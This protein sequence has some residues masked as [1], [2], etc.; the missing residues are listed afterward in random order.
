MNFLGKVLIVLNFIL[1]I[2]YLVVSGVLFT[3]R[4]I[5]K[6]E[7]AKADVQ[8]VS[9]IQFMEKGSYRNK[10]EIENI[11]QMDA[12]KGGIP[13]YIDI[14]KKLQT[15]IETS[16]TRL[17]NTVK[18]KTQELDR[19]NSDIADMGNKVEEEK[20]KR[21][22]AERVKQE[23]ENE[24]KKLTTTI[25]NLT[26]RT[27]DLNAQRDD[28]MAE[29]QTGKDEH[30]QLYIKYLDVI[31]KASRFEEE[32]KAC[33]GD[34]DVLQAKLDRAETALAYF[35]KNYPEEYKRVIG[36]PTAST[37]STRVVRGNVLAVKPKLDFVIIDKG[38]PDGIVKGDSFIVYRGAQFVGRIE[39][40]QVLGEYSAGKI[41]VKRLPVLQG[42]TVA[43]KLE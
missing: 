1:S 13:E 35:E 8:K 30:S 28:A 24:R 2:A 15:D 25:T 9:F 43:N 32:V 36:D 27:D 31:T 14:V 39:I 5:A 16:E 7:M 33:E 26:A 19:K 23:A 20:S 41:T 18:D 4:V 34:N 21:K 29:L 40:D 6:D 3:Q 22:E 42:D 38:E 12:D 10:D 11:A 37:T 17:K